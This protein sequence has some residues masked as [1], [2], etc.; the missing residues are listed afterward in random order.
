AS[1]AMRLPRRR[2]RRRI[3]PP[4]SSVTGIAVGGIEQ[5]VEVNDEIAHPRIVDARLRLRFPGIV[6]G[7]VVREDADDVE[8][9]KVGEAQSVKTFQFS[10]EDKVEQ[11]LP[12][13]ACLFLRCSHDSAETPVPWRRPTSYP[14]QVGTLVQQKALRRKYC[15]IP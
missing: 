12:V 6:G 7:A 1:R 10:P 2:L 9:G 14:I 3:F 8:V 15:G 13:S 4:V 11:L 5:A